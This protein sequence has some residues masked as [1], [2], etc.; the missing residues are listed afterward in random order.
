MEQNHRPSDFVNE[1]TISACADFFEEIALKYDFEEFITAYMN[2]KYINKNY[3]GNDYTGW[4]YPAE[5]LEAIT[6]EEPELLE[7]LIEKED[8]FNPDIANFIGECYKRISIYY[9]I[10]PKDIILNMPIKLM[11]IKYPSY[12]TFMNDDYL[13]ERLYEDYCTSQDCH[14]NGVY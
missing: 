12:H 4:M 7:H 6:T 10:L 3:A 11:V 2:C 9:D 5:M 14:K 13:T 8:D 1:Y